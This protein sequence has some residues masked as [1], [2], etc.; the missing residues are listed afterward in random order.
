MSPLKEGKAT[1]LPCA[2]FFSDKLNFKTKRVTPKEG[3][4]TALPFTIFFSSKLGPPKEEPLNPKEEKA[5]TL[6]FTD[7]GKNSCHPRRS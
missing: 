7:C 6:P 1:S 5:V 4:A 3:K 2:S